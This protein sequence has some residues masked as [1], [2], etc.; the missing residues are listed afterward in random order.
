LLGV[1]GIRATCAALLERPGAAGPACGWIFLFHR[2]QRE[3]GS[4]AAALG[5]LDALV[6]TGGIGEHAVSIREQVCSGASW[7]GIALDPAANNKGGPRVSKETVL[8]SAWTIPTNEVN[9]A[10]TPGA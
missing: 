7:L 1:S 9:D 6:F 3:I 8:C 10:G 5:G 2:I 4:L